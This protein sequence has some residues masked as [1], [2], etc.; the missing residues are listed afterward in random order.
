[1]QPIVA[2]IKQNMS[3]STGKWQFYWS[4][5]SIY[6]FNSEQ[7]CKPSVLNTFFYFYF[8]ISF[9]MPICNTSIL[10]IETRTS[11]FAVY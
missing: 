5:A 11:C 6:I 10:G 1:M 4:L 8:H 7:K 2:Y 3:Q 9:F